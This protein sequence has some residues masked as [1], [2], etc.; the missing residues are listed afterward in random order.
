MCGNIKSSFQIN[1]VF[2]NTFYSKNCFTDVSILI[3]SIKRVFSPLIRVLKK[4]EIQYYQKFTINPSIG[5]GFWWSNLLDYFRSFQNIGLDLIFE[6]FYK[7]PGLALFFLILLIISIGILFYWVSS[8]WIIDWVRYVEFTNLLISGIALVIISIYLIFLA[9]IFCASTEL[10]QALIQI[11]GAVR[12]ISLGAMVFS[13]FFALPIMIK[14]SFHSFMRTAF[15]AGGDE[16]L[17][18][19]YLR[20]FVAVFVLLGVVL[21]WVLYKTL[22]WGK[23]QTLCFSLFLLNMIMYAFRVLVRNNPIFFYGATTKLPIIYK[24][25]KRKL[26]VK[27]RLS[28]KKKIK[29]YTVCFNTMSRFGTG[30][31]I[32]KLLK[33]KYSPLVTICRRNGSTWS[34]VGVHQILLDSATDYR[35]MATCPRYILEHHVYLGGL[36]HIMYSSNST[37]RYRTFLDKATIKNLSFRWEDCDQRRRG[38]RKS[39]LCKDLSPLQRL[40]NVKEIERLSG[41]CIRISRLKRVYDTR[42]GLYCRDMG[43]SR[44]EAQ[45]DAVNGF[46]AV[47]EPNSQIIYEA[48]NFNLAITSTSL[49]VIGLTYLFYTPGEPPAGAEVISSALGL[50]RG[51]VLSP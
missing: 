31:C 1:Y 20:V 21:Q 29:R 28:L 14:N 17:Q 18:K 44:S 4:G 25:F 33:T 15:L 47:L 34:S 40:A 9:L 35:V 30:F 42:L 19:P 43:L 32:N 26:P 8:Q 22:Y 2:F 46:K 13:I 39:L 49:T 51:N 45:S 11:K 23:I 50:Y 24:K 7:A 36:E 10:S 37:L 16:P 27:R 12:R 41:E 3:S 6:I 5:G 38:I 48:K